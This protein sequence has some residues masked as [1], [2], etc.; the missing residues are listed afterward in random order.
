MVS[1][2]GRSVGG[3]PRPHSLVFVFMQPNLLLKHV[4]ALIFLNACWTCLTL[5][6]SDWFSEGYGEHPSP[7]FWD[8]YHVSSNF[9]VITS[10]MIN[11]VST[12]LVFSLEIAAI[13]HS[14]FLIYNY[15]FYLITSTFSPA[16]CKSLSKS[17]CFSALSDFLGGTLRAWVPEGHWATPTES[18]AWEFRQV[19]KHLDSTH[20]L[21]QSYPPNS[22]RDPGF[23]L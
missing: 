15:P 21:K 14:G 11:S 19:R 7:G 22:T 1:P 2:P 23:T 12:V 3:E 4:S 8:I 20:T 16:L 9:S 5:A 6:H 10:L 13:P 17:L 18:L